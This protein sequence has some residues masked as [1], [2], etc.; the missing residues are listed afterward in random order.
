MYLSHILSLPLITALGLALLPTG[1][2][3]Q[4]KSLK[5]QIVGTWTVVSNYQ[6]RQDGS[7]TN[8]FG[9]NPKGMAMFDSSGRFSWMLFGD[10]PKKFSANDRMQGTAEENKA[11]VHGTVA[12]YGTYTIDEAKGTVTYNMERS[13]FPNWDGIARTASV[14]I[15]G[16]DF[17]QVSAPIP[18][19]SGPFVPNLVFKRAK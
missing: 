13:M 14:T 9:N 19:S 2:L 6:Q 8:N 3:A 4:Q 1:A 7:R 17:K 18:S 12:Y 11:A 16:D 10:P 5:E 15:M